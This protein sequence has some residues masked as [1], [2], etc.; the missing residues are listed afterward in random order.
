MTAPAWP[1]PENKLTGIERRMLDDLRWIAGRLDQIRTT[2][3]VTDMRAEVGLIL[4][5]WTTTPAV[6]SDG[7]PVA[8]LVEPHHHLYAPP[9]RTRTDEDQP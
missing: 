9:H 1:P 7:N 6:Y 8:I 4:R 5:D 3:D 2:A